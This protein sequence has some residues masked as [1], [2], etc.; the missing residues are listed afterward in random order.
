MATIDDDTLTRVHTTNK[1]GDAM[2]LG[3]DTF[4]SLH[5]YVP[6]YLPIQSP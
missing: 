6:P 5:H 4:E 1:H 2:N 3:G